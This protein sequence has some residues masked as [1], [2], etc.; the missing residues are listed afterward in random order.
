MSSLGPRS[1]A[2][3]LRAADSVSD[4]DLF[5]A[6]HEQLTALHGRGD[7]S[8]SL[9]FTSSNHAPFE[10]PD[11][12]IALYEQPKQTVNNAVKY[13]DWALGQFFANAMQ[14]PYWHDTLFLVVADHDS[15]VYGN[16]LIPVE[17][18]RIP[19]LILGADIKAEHWDVLASQID[20]APTLL[21]LA[22]VD[23]CHPM[24]GR[25]LSLARDL[26]GRALL[27]FDDYFALMLPDR[28]RS[29]WQQ[30]TILKP[31]GSAHSRKARWP[32]FSIARA[33]TG[34]MPSAPTEAGSRGLNPDCWFFLA[35]HHPVRVRPPWVR[36]GLYKL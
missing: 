24:I 27:Q 5:S 31:D 33:G 16:N 18:F 4:E 14:S 20:L 25:D 12:R 22:G 3:S 8:F 11:G 32:V 13:A 21:S 6:V 35:R 23:S 28:Q 7:P 17:K 2:E 29:E 9:I 34:L 36:C 30:L 1:K 19:G 26:P 15:R 10:F